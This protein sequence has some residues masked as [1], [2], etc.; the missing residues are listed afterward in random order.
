MGTPPA[1]EQRASLEVRN[2]K[3]LHARPA[4][5][6][7]ETVKRFDAEVTLVKDG[8]TVNGA[9]IMGVMMLAAEQGSEVEV[10][11]SGPQAIE[12]LAALRALFEAG[13]HEREDEA[14]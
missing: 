6:L 5:L 3:G 1:D 9:S 14:K 8:H 12:V 7:V 4:G 13:F 10:V 11:T 2:K